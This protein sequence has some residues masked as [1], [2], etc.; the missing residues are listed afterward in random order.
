M[1]GGGHRVGSGCVDHEAPKLSRRLKVNI[2][3]PDSGPAHDLKPTLG[4]LEHV[5]GHL[6]PAPHDQGVVVGDLG[7][8]PASPSFSDTR[9]AGRVCFWVWAW[10]GLCTAKS[11]VLTALIGLAWDMVCRS[12]GKDVEDELRVERNDRLEMVVD[13]LWGFGIDEDLMIDDEFAAVDEAIFASFFGP[14]G[15][16]D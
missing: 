6:G 15:D 8:Q 11:T 10:A 2:V 4:R 14:H 7:G 9:I 1:L 5:S 13:L 3:D 12:V 16:N